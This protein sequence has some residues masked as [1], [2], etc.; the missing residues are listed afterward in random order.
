MLDRTLAPPFLRSTSFQLIQ[1]KKIST[2]QGADIYYILG[3][4]QEI[5]KIELIF[6]A[7]RWFEKSAG[8][9]Y[10]A[11]QLISKGTKNKSSF[12]IAELLDQYGAHLEINPGMDVVSVS[13][14]ILTRHLEPSLSLLLD[15]LTA[16][17]FPHKELEQLKSIYLQNMRVNREKTSFQASTIIRKNIF[18]ETYPYGRELEDDAV[19]AL[20]R[21]ALVDHF[22]EF[23]NPSIILVSGNINDYQGQLIA[24]AL[25]PF[26]NFSSIRPGIVPYE[27]TNPFRQIVEKDG[28]VQSSIRMGKT[29][30]ARSHRDYS[31]IL[32]LNHILGGYFGSRLMKNI[33]EEKGLSYG[34]SSSLH[35]MSM[36][37]YLMIGADVNRENLNLA[38]TEIRKELHRLRTERIGSTELETARNH[39]IG[40]LQLEITTSFA[41]ADKFKNILLFNL[42][43]DF[44]QKLIGRIDQIGADELLTI[45]EGYLNED[46]FMEVAVG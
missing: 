11:A 14:Y 38:F 16:S 12:E 39:F 40:S 4:T 45:A 27:K 7:G 21:E 1:P 41:H 6:P 17:V 44:Y 30:V 3:G 9:S 10:F 28:S 33:R 35:T 29:S 5:C 15:L 18:G 2:A 31:A 46:S 32:F 22:R 13:L 23:Y 37:S 34:I 26:S 24:R 25:S 8:A 19:I 42:P 20:P 43:E 36:N